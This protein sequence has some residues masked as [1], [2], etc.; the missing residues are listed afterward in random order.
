MAAT[1]T[2]R[3]GPRSQRIEPGVP[4][5]FG[6]CSESDSTPQREEGV[7]WWVLEVADG[8]TTPYPLL[9]QGGESFFCQES[10]TH[11][12]HSFLP[13]RCSPN[14]AEC[15]TAVSNKCLNS[16]QAREPAQGLLNEDTKIVGTNS[17]KS[18]KTKEDDCYIVQK[19]TQ[20]ELLMC[21]GN[22]PN[23]ENHATPE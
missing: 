6:R 13:S 3:P 5:H 17:K 11:P 10:E 2:I 1:M 20:N 7:A 19:R 18:L 12:T 4:R 8:P 21:R 23:G 16:E 15:Q 14:G 9:S 22:V